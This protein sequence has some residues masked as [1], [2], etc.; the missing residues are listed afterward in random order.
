MRRVGYVFGVLLLALLSLG[1]WLSV[2]H[3]QTFRSGSNVSTP[4]NGV[5]NSSLFITGQSVDVA[6]TVRGDVFC[7]GQNVHVTA[8]VQG[9][10]ICAG[11]NVTVSGRVSGDV[12]LAGQSVSLGASVSGNATI[13]TQDMT[14]ESG[15]RVDGD[16]SVSGHGVHLNGPV[17][18]DVA[19]AVTTLTVANS[20]GRNLQATVDKL[21]LAHGAYV[22]GN[23][24]YTSPNTL[25]RASGVDVDGS[26]VY[27]TPTAHHGSAVPWLLWLLYLFV[28]LLLTALLLVLLFP[29]LFHA[30]AEL[31]RGRLLRT[32]LIGLVA[33]IVVPVVLLALA[34]TIVGLPLAILAGL[35]WLL[36]VL[37]SAPFAAYLLGRLLLHRTTDNAIWTMLLGAF[38]LLVLSL[39]PFLNILVDLVAYWF[40]LGTMLQYV[41][42]LP[43]PHYH[44][45]EG[46]A[47]RPAATSKP[48]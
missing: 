41:T 22:G 29:W 14:L 16:L 37:L 44:M 31:A 19:A 21:Q 9:D 11:Q 28:A 13:L 46:V 45:A 10:V 35:F 6:G 8:T 18:R 24:T 12:R 43:R 47:N 32:F 30:A 40:G 23:V 2:A 17:G 4:S 34:L 39:V 38:I 5:V 15:A 42:R 7:A 3:A 33:S 36:V 26:I 27:H 20:V 1:G 48:I 25:T